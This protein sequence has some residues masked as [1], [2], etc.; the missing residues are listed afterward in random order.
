MG[1][2]LSSVLSQHIVQS[3]K[4]GEITPEKALELGRE[5]CRRFLKDE[6]QY[7]LAVHTDKDHIHIHCIFNN[8]NMIDGRTFE[9][10][11]NRKGDPSYKKLM[12]ISDSICRENHLSVIEDYASTKGKNH[13]EWEM[14]RQG[15]SW[16]SR[17]KNAIDEA[18]KISNDFEDFLRKCRENGIITEYNPQHK[19]DLKYMLE[20]QLKNNPRAKMTRAK[21]LG[22]FYEKK[23]IVY[24]IKNY[25]NIMDYKPTTKIIKTTSQRFI[26]SPALTCFANA[27]N[28]KEVSKAMNLLAEEGINR[29]D[30]EKAAHQSFVMKAKLSEKLNRIK[31]N[32]ED[33]DFQIKTAKKYQKFRAC[34][35]EFIS[36]SGRKKLKYESEHRDELEKFRN[37]AKLLLEWYPNGKATPIEELEQKKKVLQKE[38]S[39]KN[40]KYQIVKSELSSLTKAM[41]TIDD[42]LDNERDLQTKKRKKNDLE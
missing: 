12:N 1:T 19:I 36:L 16:K 34:Y 30:V 35:N 41:Q 9:T 21:T 39:E 24:R 33:L 23:Q 7:Y 13:Y 11:E 10:H 27:H 5:L 6:Y 2:G 15:K 28:I 17:L 29:A 31:T 3:F 38:L 22:W 18:V 8:V 40:M 4:P 37:S 20:E 42:F 25:K 26:D 14:D 32:I